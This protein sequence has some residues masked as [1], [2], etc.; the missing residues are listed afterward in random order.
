MPACAGQAATDHNNLSVKFPKIAEEWSAQNAIDAK[1]YAPN[2]GFKALWVHKQCGFAWQARISDRTANGSGCPNCKGHG[3]TVLKLRNFVASM[4]DHI[5]H[6]TPAELWALF[7]S[8]GMLDTEGKGRGFVKALATGKFP[9]DEIE[10]FAANEPSLVDEMLGDSKLNLEDLEVVD[11]EDL[12][13]EPLPTVSASQILQTLDSSTALLPDEERASFFL[14]SA[15]AKLWAHA[16]SNEAKAVKE[17]QG[18]AEKTEY[19]K[20]V[21]DTFLREYRQAKAMKLPKGYAFKI[22]NKPVKPNLM[23][24]LVAT[25]IVERGRLGNWS[26]TGAGKTLAATLASR[27]MG[28]DITV[29]CC[30]NNV[31]DGWKKAILEAFPQADVQTKTFDP[32]WSKKK[33]AGRYLVLNYE[34]FQ[35]QSSSKRLRKFLT[36]HKIDFLVID[37]I[38]FAKQRSAELLSKRRE[39]VTAFS[40]GA[41]KRNK[42]L[43]VLGMSATP[44][45][46]NLQEGRSVIEMITGVPREDICTKASV[47]NCMRLHQIFVNLGIRQIPRYTTGFEQKEIEID[48]SD[49]VDEIRESRKEKSGPLALE[50]ILTR[51]RLPVILKALTRKTIVYTYNVTGIVE[52]LQEAIEANGWKVGLFIGEDKTGLDKF[53]KET[54]D[55]LIA[56]SA[57]G[58]GIDGLQTVCSKMVMNTLP[59]TNAEFE[60][61]KGRIFRQGQKKPVTVVVPITKAEVNGEEWSWCRS[62]YNRLLW[63]KSVA[64]AALDG[65]VPEGHLRSPSEAYKDHMNWLNRISC[66]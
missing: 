40:F 31:V 35:L 64:D 13:D 12:K 48:C 60:Q 14:A 27:L 57:V 62:K 66:D 28:A 52:T 21:R 44:V 15:K 65:I 7:D 47:L 43:R 2:S 46:N 10:K 38:H 6:M 49:L 56:S 34:Q 24:R 45:I 11:L 18:Y 32:L 58:V 25:Q 20:S 3:W 9:L 29:I 63:K 5:Q 1:K 16:F 50:Q 36:K 59:W 26:G 54:V 17:I 55:I 8:N 42:A 33:P 41:G 61:L 39:N 30:P 37:E 22:D 23:Q 51:A 4:K 19:S 53:L